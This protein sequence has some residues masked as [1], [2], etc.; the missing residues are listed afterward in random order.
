M[1]LGEVNEPTRYFNFIYERVLKSSQFNLH[2]KLV[3]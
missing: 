2:P 1:K 3:F